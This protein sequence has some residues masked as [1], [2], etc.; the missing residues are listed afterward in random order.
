M[1]DGL[2]IEQQRALALASA[3]QRMQSQVHAPAPAKPQIPSLGTPA[4]I[5]GGPMMA[6]YNEAARSFDKSIGEGAYAGGGT[7]T[8]IASRAGASPEMAAGAGTV[9]NAGIR[10]IPTIAGTIAGKSLEPIT[11]NFP[12]LGSRALMMSALNPGAHARQTGDAKRAV[13]TLLEEG[14]NVSAGGAAKLRTIADQ[15]DDE[16]GRRIA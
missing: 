1:A 6:I 14:A 5:A 9:A 2:T 3:R 8:D 4:P 13:E 10:A 16:V 11:R 15:L 12:V 7:V